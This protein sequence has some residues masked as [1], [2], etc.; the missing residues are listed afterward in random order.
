MQFAFI[1]RHQLFQILVSLQESKVAQFPV[2]EQGVLRRDT[3]SYQFP[4]Y[5]SQHITFSGTPLTDKHLYKTIT[6]VVHDS[7]GISYPHETEVKISFCPEIVLPKYIHSFVHNLKSL[8]KKARIS[9]I[10]ERFI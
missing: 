10:N 5:L 8:Q 7:A 3:V 4:C 2:D 6:Y 9:I 1:K